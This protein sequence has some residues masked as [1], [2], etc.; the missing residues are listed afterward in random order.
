MTAKYF[1]NVI[2]SENADALLIDGIKITG[3]QN[4][5]RQTFFYLA[6]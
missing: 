1:E 4:Q 2:L 3:L 6:K 5:R